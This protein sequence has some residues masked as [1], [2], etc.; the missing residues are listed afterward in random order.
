[1]INIIKELIRS[2]FELLRISQF[3]RPSL[4][5]IDREVEPFI[6]YDHGTFLEIGANNGYSQSNTYYFE[7]IR[8]WKGILIEPI[9]QLYEECVKRRKRSHVFNYACGETK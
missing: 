5:H 1:M 6:D 8:R 2:F 4:N 3:S 9:P 7:K